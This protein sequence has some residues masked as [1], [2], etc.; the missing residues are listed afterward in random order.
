VQFITGR[1]VFIGNNQVIKKPDGNFSSVIFA[2][3][4][5]MNKKPR[6]IAFKCYG[7]L[8]EKL[9]DL[10]IDDKVEVEYLIDSKKS[11]TDSWWTNLQARGVERIITE[12]KDNN[13]S[14]LKFYEDGNRSEN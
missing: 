2:I 11:N 4:K 13:T 6:N 9:L 12:K 1:I 8:A 14:Q 10:R 3:K 7:K 5:R